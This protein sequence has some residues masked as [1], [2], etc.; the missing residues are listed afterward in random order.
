MNRPASPPNSPRRQTAWIA[1]CLLL[2]AIAAGPLLLHPGFLNTR[3][4]GD[5]P[6]LLF[7]LH[8]L[9]TALAD[10]VF[11]VRWMPDATFG[12]GYPFFNYYAALPFYI[13]ALF[14]ALGLSYVLSLKLTHLLGFLIAAWGMFAW[15]EDTSHS[16]PAALLASA[17]YT[18]APYHLVNVYVRGDSLVEFWAMAWF[19]VILLALHRAARQ[20]TACRLVLVALAYGALVMTHNISA[21]IF[22]PFVA[23]YG[24]GES[25]LNRRTI[26]DSRGRLRAVLMLGLAGL[27]GLALAAWVWLPALGEQQYAQLGEQTTGYFHY[28]NHFR[29]TDLVQPSFFFNYDPSPELPTPFSMGLVQAIL[30]G[31]GVIALALRMVRERAWWR[32]GFVLTGL[33]ISTLMITPLS[34]PLWARL[35]LLSFAQFP[36]RFLSVQAVFC[37]AAVGDISSVV[38]SNRSFVGARTRLRLVHISPL[39]GILM[40]VAALGA[41]RPDFILLT[42]ADVTPQRLM[43]YESFT[44]N[45]GTTIRYEYLPVWTQPRPYTSDMLLKREPRAKFMQGEGEVHRIE[46]RAASQ[47]WAFEVES[48]SAQVALPLL[49]WPGWR[50]RLIQDNTGA[51]YIVPLQTRPLEGLGYILL[52]VPQGEYTVRVWLGRT[53]LRLAAEIASL[54]ALVGVVMLWRPR[55]P[56]WGWMEWGWAA[57]GV[58]SAAV[59][60]MVLHSIPVKELEGPLNADFAQE[61]Y[62]HHSPAGFEFA[63][64]P[65]IISAPPQQVDQGGPVIQLGEVDALVPGLYFP[66]NPHPDLAPLTSSGK[67]RGT[68]YLAPLIAS[69]SGASMP[70]I[71]I[72]ANFTIARLL[73]VSTQTGLEKIV[74]ALWWEALTE[75]SRNYAIALRLYDAAGNEWAALDTQA[76][77]AG[78][79][80]TGL[81]S[82]GEIVHDNY[83][84]RLPPGT[85]PGNYKLTVTVYDFVTLDPIGMAEIGGVLYDHT[86]AATCDDT[87]TILHDAIRFSRI[88]WSEIIAEGEPLPVTI[89]WLICEKLEEHYQVR[90]MLAPMGGSETRPYE[91]IT[92][93]APG[94]DPV[95]WVGSPAAFVQG[96]HRLDLPRDLPPGEYMLSVQ[97]VSESGELLGDPYEVGTVRLE[98]R[99]RSFDV[100]PLDRLLE[101]SF[102]DQ[103]KLWGYSLTQ[104][105]DALTLDVAWGAVSDPAKDYKFFVHLFD[106]ATEQITAQIDTMPREYTYP[107]SLWVMGEV[108]SETLRLD[109]T[110]VPPGVYRI[111]LGWYDPE[112]DRL[113]AFDAAGNLL[114]DGRVILDEIIEIE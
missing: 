6:F 50:A 27:L 76:G 55:V 79:Y 53:P 80:P 82:P 33:I 73:T 83:S 22:S 44:G 37:A 95:M 40:G 32:D 29:S 2:G 15:M 31:A 26:D 91:I 96:R 14:K 57:G 5:S 23:A 60:A 9:Y 18:F 111:A 65:R 49:Y 70:R 75:S 3:S 16:K 110:G 47:V 114:P 101:I 109:L 104:S 68:V 24:L 43:W 36:W 25:L 42:D 58:T 11:P 45:I 4:G 1:A 54:I 100:P 112:S 66:V 67:K 87:S 20:P 51:R 86:S 64:L 113:P 39:L 77:G 59:L 74:P 78:M 30:T 93:L 102:G 103:L 81:W 61:A 85:P 106:P 35:P 46:G 52:D 12:L 107:T 62:F 13:A 92:D 84:L 41:I 108:V 98:G 34:Q 10:G 89:D 88:E 21:L 99:A 72:D 28:S 38:L 7:R 63:D 48:E 19:P 69:A 97:L 105:A 90:W 56:L 17:A 94:S 8:Q 71:T